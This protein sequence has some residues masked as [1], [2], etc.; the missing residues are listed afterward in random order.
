MSNRRYKSNAVE[1]ICHK[2]TYIHVM[3]SLDETDTWFSRSYFFSGS[4]RNTE[5]TIYIR[6]SPLHPYGASASSTVYSIYEDES[7]FDWKTASKDRSRAVCVYAHVT[8]DAVEIAVFEKIIFYLTRPRLMRK[9]FER[10][11]SDD[12]ATLQSSRRLCCIN[13]APN[14]MRITTLRNAPGWNVTSNYKSVFFLINC[15]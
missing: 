11:T 14:I 5:L 12:A 10:L 15:L 13:P 7:I 2:K 4:S 3:F 6:L 8:N 9:L 1:G